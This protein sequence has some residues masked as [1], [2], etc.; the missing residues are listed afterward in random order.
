VTTN[1]AIEVDEAT[2]TT[3]SRSYFTMLQAL[4][5][6]PLQ[7]ITADRPSRRREGSGSHR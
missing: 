4:P 3:A 1:T 7:T 6:L 5:G 2:G